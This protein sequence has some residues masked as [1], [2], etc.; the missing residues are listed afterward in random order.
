MNQ[1]SS[2]WKDFN[3]QISIPCNNF[4]DT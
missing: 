1:E 2:Y 4:E 3:G